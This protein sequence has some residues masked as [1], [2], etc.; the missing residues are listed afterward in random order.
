M[1]TRTG[2]DPELLQAYIDGDADPAMRARIDAAFRADPAL[3]AAFDA[4]AARDARMRARLRDTFDPALDEVA[5]AH[6]LALLTGDEAPRT[7]ERP[8][9]EY[10][11]AEH[12]VVEHAVAERALAASGGPDRKGDDRAG[13]GDASAP[14]ASVAA[15]PTARTARASATQASSGRRRAPRRWPPFVAAAAVAALTLGLWLR[16]Q[17]PAPLWREADGIRIATGVLAEGLDRAL[18]SAPAPSDAVRIG[19]SF[20]DREGRWCRSFTLP[21]E[22]LAGLACRRGDGWRLVASAALDAPPVDGDTLRQASADLPPAI[23]DAIDARIAGDAAEAGQE[24][25]ARAADWR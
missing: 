5:P 7:G 6:L 17:A 13:T 25:A 4:A 21:A 20:R 14:G 8:A 3:R 11:V 24:R 16:T 18:A 1:N 15:L 19:L 22:A 23:R 9:A 10:A 12:A 2:I